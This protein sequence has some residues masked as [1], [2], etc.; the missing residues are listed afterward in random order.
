MC[1]R[2][3]HVPPRP[4]QVARRCVVLAAIVFAASPWRA[5]GQ[6]GDAP[7]VEISEAT[8]RSGALAVPGARVESLAVSPLLD[9]MGDIGEMG[10]EEGEQ[11]VVAELEGDGLAVWVRLVGGDGGNVAQAQARSVLRVPDKELGRAAAIRTVASMP[12]SAAGPTACTG[13]R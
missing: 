1:V 4:R 2:A 12:I 3:S 10:E 9:S 6:D 5:R 8:I 13:W 7:P 11:R